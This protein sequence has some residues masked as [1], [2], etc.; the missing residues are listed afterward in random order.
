[1]R[2]FN[3][4]SMSAFICGYL[5]SEAF[6][7]EGYMEVTSASWDLIYQIKLILSQFNIRTTLNKKE[8]KAYPDNDYWRLNL[9]GV[10]YRTYADKIGLYLFLKNRKAK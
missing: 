5:D 4:E 10:D 1:M 6:F 7:D 9:S 3:K 8:A 2:S